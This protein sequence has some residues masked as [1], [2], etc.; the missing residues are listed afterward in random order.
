MLNEKINDPSKNDK[1]NNFL[2]V[3]VL[4]LTKINVFKE[5]T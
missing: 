4:V 5:I 1:V 3:I 2:F